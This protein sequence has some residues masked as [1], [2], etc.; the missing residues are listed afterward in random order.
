MEL[1]N[2][3]TLCF[4]EFGLG[5]KILCNKMIYIYMSVVFNLFAG[6]EPQENIPVT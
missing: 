5:F 3:F 2:I 1:A 4:I 6:A